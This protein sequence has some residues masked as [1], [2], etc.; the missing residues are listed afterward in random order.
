MKKEFSPG[1]KKGYHFPFFVTDMIKDRVIREK[2]EYAAKNNKKVLFLFEQSDPNVKRINDPVIIDL[3]HLK[4]KQIKPQS[5]FFSNEQ[6]FIIYNNKKDIAYAV[7]S[8]LTKLDLLNIAKNSIQGPKYPHTLIL[9]NDKIYIICNIRAYDVKNKTLIYIPEDDVVTFS[10]FPEEIDRI[11][12]FLLTT[13]EYENYSLLHCYLDW[14][15]W[16]SIEKED[17]KEEV[18]E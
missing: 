9:I 16:V 5:F 13:Q 18:K 12:P 8:P 10:V 14:T 2:C 11:L 7:S 6:M 1:K 3:S 4:Q 15:V 17:V